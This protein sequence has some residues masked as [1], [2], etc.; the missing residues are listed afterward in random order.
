MAGSEMVFAATK[1]V[2]ALAKGA[3]LETMFGVRVKELVLDA[4]GAVSGR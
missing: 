1:H 3:N 2:K 4:N